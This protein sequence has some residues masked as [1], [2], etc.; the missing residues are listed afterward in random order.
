MADSL[1]GF[2][3]SDLGQAVRGE[4]GARQ[5]SNHVVT[6]DGAPVVYGPYSEDKAGRIAAELNS[7]NWMERY[8]HITPI[9]YSMLEE[10]L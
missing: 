5:V 2:S 10:V 7:G 4:G 9:R 1:G 8:W 6:S 3:A